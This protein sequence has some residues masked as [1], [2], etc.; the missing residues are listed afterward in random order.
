MSESLRI[1]LARLDEALDVEG[2]LLE[3]VLFKLV[4]ARLMRAGGG[5]GD[6]A[7]S[8]RQV[9]ASIESV[10]AA[11]APR[12]SLLEGLAHPGSALSLASLAES[13]PE[14][15][16]TMLADHLERFRAISVE[17]GLAEAAAH[18]PRADSAGWDLMELQLAEV[19]YRAARGLLAGSIASSLRPF[20]G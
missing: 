7:R 5:A 20:L 1:R 9:E 14:P 2:A 11:A 12:A 15:Y 13:A 10:R 17:M 16:R 18:Q 6:V 8:V 19:S 4:V 3:Q